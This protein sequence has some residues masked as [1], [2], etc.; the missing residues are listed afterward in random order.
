MKAKTL[1]FVL[2][3]TACV[4]SARLFAQQS[5]AAVPD[6]ADLI[7]PGFK[8]QEPGP[9]AL[10]LWWDGRTTAPSAHSGS[11]VFAKDHSLGIYLGYDAQG[12]WI[13]HNSGALYVFD[14][15]SG[16]LR[17]GAA[18]IAQRPADLVRPPGADGP[19]TDA[20]ITRETDGRYSL[21]YVLHENGKSDRTLHFSGLSPGAGLGN[22]AWIG[23]P[24]QADPVALAAADPQLRRLLAPGEPAGS[25]G[26]VVVN[27]RGEVRWQLQSR[28]MSA[29]WFARG[30][31]ATVTRGAGGYAQ[32]SFTLLIPGRADQHLTLPVTAA[33]LI[34]NPVLERVLWVSGGT[35]STLPELVNLPVSLELS[36]VWVWVGAQP[37]DVQ[38]LL[39]QVGGDGRVRWS[40]VS[41]ASA[42]L[43][44]G[45]TVAD[46]QPANPFHSA[47][48]AADRG[49]PLAASED[50][51]LP[52]LTPPEGPPFD[53][54]IVWR[55][56]SGPTPS[57]WKQGGGL[58]N[59]LGE[60]WVYL[61]FNSRGSWLETPAGRDIYVWDGAHRRLTR[62]GDS[63]TDVPTDLAN[64][65]EYMRRYV[66]ARQ[67]SPVPLATPALA[68]GDDPLQ[69]AGLV[70]GHPGPSSFAPSVGDASSGS[71]AQLHN[72]VL[73]FTDVS[74]AKVSLKVRRPA[75]AQ[76]PQF[77]AMG[78][79]GMWIWLSDDQQQA[80]VVNVLPN[81]NVT[82]TVIPAQNASS[83]LG[84][85]AR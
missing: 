19:R 2:S 51:S 12:V 3:C 15:R 17:V 47:L 35:G 56:G 79:A 55:Y 81:G 8:T 30:E 69:A 39:L 74:G 20:L 45:Y 83:M 13:E 65:S 85:A 78:S 14:A 26:I 82:L 57:V 67:A 73:S 58:I 32:L 34:L 22:W 24:S 16:T 11:I 42:R 50:P 7:L 25:A 9:A 84:A 66:S 76:G 72:G 1:A 40:L 71:G 63:M 60:E 41:A 18:S 27:S 70:P 4:L 46:S 28:A 77:A 59:D 61:G 33:R 5:G 36:S 6:P 44:L 38:G 31:H 49:T 29:S 53:T 48:T 52:R 80:R 68:G 64:P 54:D 10:P 43:L 37:T 62:V 21:S 75:F 23:E